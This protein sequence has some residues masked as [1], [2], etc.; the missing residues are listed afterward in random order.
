MMV[1]NL[2]FHFV[3]KLNK[4]LLAVLLSNLKYELSNGLNMLWND[5]LIV[6]VLWLFK[7]DSKEGSHES[8]QIQYNCSHCSCNKKFIFWKIWKRQ[9]G[10]NYRH[11]LN[12]RFK[13]Q[14]KYNI[15]TI[16]VVSFAQLCGILHL[17]QFFVVVEA[18]SLKKLEKL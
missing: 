8:R 17:L 3:N 18:H 14:K 11:N 5:C 10:I 15:V 4:K 2:Q 12:P 1:R 9:A 7:V 16:Y 13:V 6:L